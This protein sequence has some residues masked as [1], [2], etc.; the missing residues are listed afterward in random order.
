MPTERPVPYI[1]ATWIASLLSGDN[2]CE[3][4]AWFRAHYQHQKRPSTFD[5]VKWRA[6]HA[7]M[8]RSRV[9][10]LVKEKYDIYVEKQ[11]KFS[12]LGRVATVAGTPD[13]IALREQDAWVID[14]KTGQ[15]KDSHFFQVLIYMAMLP[16]TH[17]ACEGRKLGGEIQYKDFSVLI[18]P[19]ELTEQRKAEIRRMIQRIAAKDAPRKVPSLYECRD[20]PVAPHYC[21]ERIDGPPSDAAPEH[22]LF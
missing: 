21:P 17:D 15:Q 14:C 2:H 6:A 19:D 1:W 5:E 10:D 20:C 4:A 9:H 3:W 8:V 12:L 22:D 7:E 18:K 13:I 16:V 11:N